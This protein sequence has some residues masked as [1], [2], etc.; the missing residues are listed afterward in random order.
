MFYEHKRQGPAIN[1]VARILLPLAKQNRN[2]RMKKG[3]YGWWVNQDRGIFGLFRQSG[4]DG[5]IPLAFRY[6]GFSNVTGTTDVRRYVL[7][8]TFLLALVA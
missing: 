7:R 4:E 6:S 1:C 8:A 3:S 2:A 5:R